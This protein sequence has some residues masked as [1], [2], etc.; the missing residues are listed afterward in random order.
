[1]SPRVAVRDTP[2]LKAFSQRLRAA[3]KRAQVAL[4]ACLRTL[5]TRRNALGNHQTLWQPQEVSLDESFPLTTKTVAPLCYAPLRL[6]AAA[7]GRLA[8][9]TDLTLSAKIATFSVRDVE[10]Q[11]VPSCP[12]SSRSSLKK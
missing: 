12:R 7:R 5:W 8:S 3:G 2:G 4:P 10:K 9:Q 6:P 11:E 1:M